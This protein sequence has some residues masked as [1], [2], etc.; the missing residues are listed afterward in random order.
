MFKLKK[1]GLSAAIGI[2]TAAVT[3]HTHRNVSVL[4][5]A[6]YAVKKYPGL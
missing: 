4:V 2:L 6:V 1:F 5:A 3:S